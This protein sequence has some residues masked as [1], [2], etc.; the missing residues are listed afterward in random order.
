MIVWHID[1]LR[2]DLMSRNPA[3]ATIFPD[4]NRVAVAFVLSNGRGD[5][6][7]CG[8]ENCRGFITVGCPPFIG[9]VE[10]PRRFE[11]KCPGSP[12]TRL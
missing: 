4:N 11:A 7:C 9:H 5:R 8:G 3:N 1:L 12:L 6:F 2:R 10:I